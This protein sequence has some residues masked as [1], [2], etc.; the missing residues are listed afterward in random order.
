MRERQTERETWSQIWRRSLTAGESERDR[1]E[2]V[3]ET[4]QRETK[5]RDCSSHC[6]RERWGGEGGTGR[7]EKER[8]RKGDGD[9]DVFS[10]QERKRWGGE[11]QSTGERQREMS[12]HCKREQR[13]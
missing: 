13:G 8:E 6:G 10:L 4:E 12:S 11:R 1:T 5:Q 2:R 3:R 7:R 9:R